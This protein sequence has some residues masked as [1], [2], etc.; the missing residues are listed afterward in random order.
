MPRQVAEGPRIQ[1]LWA[2]ERV[3]D[4]AR[5]I[6]AIV[7]AEL[8]RVEFDANPNALRALVRIYR[9]DGALFEKWTPCQTFEEGAGILQPE[10]ER[11]KGEGWT[12]VSLDTEPPADTE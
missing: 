11:L 8:R 5:V 7:S 4:G 12:A 2:F 3:E 9:A 6:G 10:R 1:R